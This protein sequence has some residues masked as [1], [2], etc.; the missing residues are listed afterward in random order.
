MTLVGQVLVRSE[1]FDQAGGLMTE[2]VDAVRRSGSPV[3]LPVALAT[4]AEL[5]WWTGDWVGAAAHASEALRWSEELGQVGAIG[6]CLAWLARFDAARGDLTRCR[7][8]VWAA[9]EATAGH[10]IDCLEVYLPAAIG[11]G[12]LGS[13]EHGLAIETLE[14]AWRAGQASG[15]ANANVVPFVADLVEAHVHLGNRGRAAELAGWL[16][17]RAASTGL[18]YPAASAAR[19]R[20][21]LADDPDSRAAAFA[22]ARAAHDRL[23]APFERARTLLCEAQALRRGRR[24]RAARQLLVEA[25]RAFDTLGAR[26]WAHGAAAELAATGAEAE[27]S[28]PGPLA[29]LS[30]QEVQIARMIAGGLS[31]GETA[32]ALFLS[33]RTVEA[34]L[35]RLYRKLDVRSRV[36][37]ARVLAAPEGPTT[38]AR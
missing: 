5:D 19:C 29:A 31:T 30:P 1:R 24:R 9:R 25:Q 2:L 16:E 36:A 8:H 26:A 12:A 10:R 37:L 17:D 23:P 20:G 18:A 35:G 11:L 34:H 3:A 7:E 14:Q 15:L 6:Y 21:L 13:G 33:H 32:A 28:P 38:G 4:R 27:Q 22:A